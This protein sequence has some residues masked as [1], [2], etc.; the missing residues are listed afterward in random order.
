MY[1]SNS[2]AVPGHELCSEAEC[3]HDWRGVVDWKNS[4]CWW[5]QGED[6]CGENSSLISVHI[7]IVDRRE[8]WGSVG[9]GQ[10]EGLLLELGEADFIPCTGWKSLQGNM[11]ILAVSLA[12]RKGMASQALCQ[13]VCVGLAQFYLHWQNWRWLTALAGC[14][15]CLLCQTSTVNHLCCAELPVSGGHPVEIWHHL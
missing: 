2:S 13:G 14:H 6:Y 9:T 10:P 11:G 1:H 7:S 3:S 5:N 8:P 4:S 12:V 15:S